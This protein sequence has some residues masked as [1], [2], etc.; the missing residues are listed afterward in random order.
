[1]Y[2]EAKGFSG[3]G[4]LAVRRPELDK[5]GP[6]AGIQLAEDMDWGA[7][8]VRAGH[9]AREVPGMIVY[10]PARTTLAELETKWRRHVGH[11][12]ALHRARGGSTAA[13]VA[14]AAA[15]LLSAIPHSMALFTSDRLAG[16]AN[17]LRGVAVLWRT[18]AFR[19][20]EML[21]QARAP[22]DNAAAQWNR[23]TA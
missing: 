15:V 1:M 20:R 11:D 16:F 4:N 22:G 5:V 10:H 17:R 3:T 13:W 21:R 14:R 12:F 8:A 9:P 23:D 6:Y 2:I 7:R 19:F 18:R